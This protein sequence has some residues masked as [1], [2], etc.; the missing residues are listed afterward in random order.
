MSSRFLVC[1]IFT[2]L[3]SLPAAA[4]T[5]NPPPALGN[6]DVH[7]RI[8]EIARRFAE[9]NFDPA[10]NLIGAHSKRPP[11]TKTHS[12]RESAYYAYGLLLT[13]D[14][15]DRA[16]AQAILR[17]VVTLQ[18]TKPGS[19]TFGAFNWNAE[20][21]PSDQNSAAFV[22]STLAAILDLD[23]Q[24]PVLD[25]DL[26]A[27]AEKSTRFAVQAVMMRN[28]D[29]GY[30]NIAFLSTALAAAGEKFLHV[31]GS[32]AW[33]EKELT[34]ILAL[35]DDGEFAEYLSPT[36]TGVAIQGAYMARRFAFSDPFGAKV[37]QAINHLWKQ[38]ALSYFP[39][40]CQLG[41]PYLRAYGDNMLNYASVLKYVLYLGL[42]GAYPL[43]D[44]EFDHDW[45]LGCL[46]VLADL[47]IGTRPE[48]N[49]PAPAWRAWDAVGTSPT[50][51]RHLFQYREGNFILG[52]VANQDEW[53]QKRNLVASWRND[54]PPPLGFKVGFCID[55]SNESLPGFAGE[56][57]HFYSQQVKGAAIV[58]IAASTDVPGQGVST[59]V[60]D[61]GGQALPADATGPFRVQDGSMTAYLYPVSTASPTY[62]VVPDPDH[63]VMRVTRS[64]NSSDLVGNLHVMAYVIVFRPA[65]QAA[66]TVTDISLA[67]GPKGVVTAAASVDGVPLS[68]NFTD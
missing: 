49:T 47:P 60:F 58:A 54:G 66:P 32:G 9:T 24:H 19:P 30:T 26:R 3:I 48:F 41:G 1:F 25:A 5:W 53:K 13:G 4:A 57:L 65:D 28:V 14:P 46:F 10:A 45:D 37:D 64:W 33:A 40:T 35:A 50:P 67:S 12:T 8:Y 63:H 16:R 39:P 29:P 36:Y 52:T 31:P 6:L 55:E 34:G 68:V 44:T 17:R 2:V 11:N 43:N 56:K 7:R 42:N 23:R 27:Q 22:G 62:T 18:D 20:D 51:V 61:D 38:V 21:P 59:L 15:A